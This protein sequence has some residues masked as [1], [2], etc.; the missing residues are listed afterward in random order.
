M[1]K[2]TYVHT[3]HTARFLGGYLY[4]SDFYFKWV[5]LSSFSS[6][7]TVICLINTLTKRGIVELFQ[8]PKSFV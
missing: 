6:D 2:L 5:L 1:V 7:S 8:T 4:C 3:E